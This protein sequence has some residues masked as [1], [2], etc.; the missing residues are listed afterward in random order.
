M[1]LRDL[2][3]E[4][5]ERARTCESPEELIALAISE[6]IDITDEQLESING[7]VAGWEGCPNQTKAT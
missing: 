4:Q 1:D 6:G 2:T 5:K 3:P 7:G